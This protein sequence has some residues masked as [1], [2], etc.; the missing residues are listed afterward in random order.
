MGASSTRMVQQTNTP[1]GHGELKLTYLCRVR[2]GAVTGSRGHKR[3]L[4]LVL[5]T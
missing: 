1:T 5:L 3:A 4:I 2:L